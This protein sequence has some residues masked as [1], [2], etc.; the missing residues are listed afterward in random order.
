[1]LIVCRCRLSHSFTFIHCINLYFPILFINF[2]KEK[3]VMRKPYSKQLLTT[4]LTLAASLFARAQTV[5]VNSFEKGLKQPSVQVFDVRT[6]QEFNTGHLSDALQ[7]DY[8]N[9]PEFAHRVQYLDKQKP[10]Y[11]Y[12]LSGGRSSAAAKWMRE[13]GFTQ[14]VEMQGG[15]N[16]WKQAGKPLAG[17]TA[18]KQLAVA[19]YQQTISKGLV[20]V[21]VGA[22]WCPPCRTMEPVIKQFLQ[23]HPQV[24]LVKVDGGR[25]QEVMQA[26]KATTLPTFI[27]Y[28]DGKETGRKEGVAKLEELE[29]VLK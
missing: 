15:I 16:A 25:D 22:A 23:E 18:V 17:V 11:I 1:M 3:Q 2:V 14:V 7:A 4:L 20:L 12:C 5:D 27:V 9:K 26:E 29:G 19:D 10:V 13:N 6:A 21:D 28:K 8:T 24:Q